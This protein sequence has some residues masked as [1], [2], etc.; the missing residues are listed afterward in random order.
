MNRLDPGAKNL[1][2]IAPRVRGQRDDP[3]QEALEQRIESGIENDDRGPD[4]DNLDKERRPPDDRHIGIRRASHI[5][6]DAVHD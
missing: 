2:L 6:L 1:A 4:E 3:G 5:I